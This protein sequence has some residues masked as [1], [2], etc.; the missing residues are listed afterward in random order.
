[1]SGGAAGGSKRVLHEEE[2]E[3]DAEAGGARCMGGG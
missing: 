2:D 3:L 1:M